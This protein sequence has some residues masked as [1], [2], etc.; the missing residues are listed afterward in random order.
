MFFFSTNTDYLCMKCC[1]YDQGQPM[2][3]QRLYYGSLWKSAVCHFSPH[4]WEKESSLMIT[5]TVWQ[6]PAHGLPHLK[7]IHSENMYT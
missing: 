3:E 7:F 1:S 2:E 4:R 6:L 5:P